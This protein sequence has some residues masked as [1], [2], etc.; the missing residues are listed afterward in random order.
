MANSSSFLRKSTITNRHSSI[1]L[2]T[3]KWRNPFGTNHLSQARA[4]IRREI[5]DFDWQNVYVLPP[6]QGA[7][8]VVDV[9]E[10]LPV[11]SD[12]LFDFLCS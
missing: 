9:V 4:K 6:G 2:P 3:A 7:A 5:D 10:L 1:L 8:I 11:G 12:D